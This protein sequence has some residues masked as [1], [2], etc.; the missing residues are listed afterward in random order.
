MTTLWSDSLLSVQL[1]LDE[2]AKAVQ[3]Y[4]NGGSEGVFRQKRRAEDF[5]K[6]ELEG[7][8]YASLLP[9]LEAST[10][11]LRE[12][13]A[14]ALAES[15]SLLHMLNHSRW[16]S[17]KKTTPTSVREENAARLRAVLG[18]FKSQGQFRL[19]DNF[20][21]LF[22]ERTGEPKESIPAL[23]YAA[24]NLFRCQVF[25][26]TLAAFADILVE[27]LE[28]LLEIE[29]ANPKPAFQFPGGGTAK[30]AVDAANDKEGGNNPLDM[31]V[32]GDEAS[33]T[34]TLVE[35]KKKKGQDKTKEPKRYGEGSSR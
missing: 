8:D 33:S 30:A 32:S 27:W 29:K 12:A 17:P 23:T 20:K 5:A 28:L 35:G 18:E 14:D 9:A 3:R 2:R 22:D 24:R 25:T 4:Q 6:H 7:T 31:G 15:I 16:T 19:L 1:L 13:A 26:T 10:A 34:S 11:P 21:D